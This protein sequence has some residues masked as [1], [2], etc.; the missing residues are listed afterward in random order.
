M[1]FKLK[2]QKG[3]MDMCIDVFS[4]EVAAHVDKNCLCRCNC[5]V[6]LSHISL[7]LNLR[8]YTRQNNLKFKR[9]KKKLFYSQREVDR[10]LLYAHESC[11]NG[12]VLCIK[13][14]GKVFLSHVTSV[15]HCM[16][17]THIKD[18]DRRTMWLECEN[19][20]CFPPVPANLALTEV[21][22]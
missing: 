14:E 13:E 9:E 2:V 17:T 3:W 12:S 6:P 22:T 15:S 10:D 11:I 4:K 5:Q 21:S 19:S 1:K 16:L 8:K 7:K 20:M 18:K